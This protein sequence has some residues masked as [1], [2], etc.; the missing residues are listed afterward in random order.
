MK[1]IIVPTDF[2]ANADNAL[3][4]TCNMHKNI[5]GKI[6]L[7]HTYSVPAVVGDDYL[8]PPL[9]DVNELKDMSDEILN[10]LALAYQKEFPAMSFVIESSLGAGS[11]AEE[12]L[13]SAEH[14][15]ADLIII[16]TH[17]TS[18]MKEFLFGT[19]AASVMADAKCAVLSVP[20]NASFNGMKSIVYAADYGRH[21]F[22]HLHRVIDLVK[23][24]GSEIILLHVAVLEPDD[25]MADHEIA[26]FKERIVSE[27]GYANISY[28]LIEDNDVYHGVHSYVEEFPPDMLVMSMRNRSF[29]EKIFGRSLTKRMSYH[30]H[31]PV[32]A[33]HING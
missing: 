10:K 9:P 33:L 20:E 19:T 24:F 32:L 14:H 18:G 27:T 30:S 13:G 29:A 21:N 12:V 31:V 28:R 16:G 3:R 25:A 6:V 15:K 5:E 22:E 23:K 2:S 7:F 1:T 8:I 17:G 4:Y 11:V 26:Q